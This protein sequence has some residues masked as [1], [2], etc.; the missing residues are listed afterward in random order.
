MSKGVNRLAQ[1][2]DART[3][4]RTA[5]PSITDFGT[6]TSDGSLQLDQFGPP[7]PRSEYLV[8]EWMVDAIIPPASRTY[9]SASPVNASGGNLPDTTTSPLSRLDFSGGDNSSHVPNVELHF[10]RSLRPGDRVIV[11]WVRDDPVIIGK[12]VPANA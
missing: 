12:V 11:L 5:A 7:I 4:K 8:A 2:I 10:S 9:R 6:I 1:A 3:N